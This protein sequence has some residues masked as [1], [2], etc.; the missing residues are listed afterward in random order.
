[1][2]D[3]TISIDQGATYQL[4]ITVKQGGVPFDLTGWAAR[5]QFR[6]SAES[7]DVLLDCTQSNGRIKVSEDGTLGQIEVLLPAVETGRFVFRDAVFDVLISKGAE[8]R[9]VLRGSVVIVPAV[10]R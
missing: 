4:A 6:P 10:T 7:G 8:S 1:M 9:R 2:I 5:M 3:F